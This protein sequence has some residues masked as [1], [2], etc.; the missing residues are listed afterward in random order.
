M[1][2]LLLFLLVVPA[3]AGCGSVAAVSLP[4][5]HAASPQRADLNWVESIGDQSGRLV[6]GVRS[7]EVTKTGWQAS[8]SITNDTPVPFA[9]GVAKLR[10]SLEFGLM[11]F[12]TG[13]HSE[14]E[15]RNAKRSLPAIR[16][17][18]T[19]V[20]ALPPQLEAHKAWTGTISA[21]G[22]VAAGTWARVVFGALLPV[23][24]ST[25]SGTKPEPTL[26]DALRKANV[27]SG[28]VWITD[29]AYQLKR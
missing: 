24:V 28:V 9:I 2:R 26:P 15:D 20:P 18:E 7:F 16:P 1:R 12:S 13:A 8:I 11:L 14:L 19:Y 22:P 25:K 23:S 5:A 17:A 29:H 4:P 3:L 21:G 10:E 6:F 27:G